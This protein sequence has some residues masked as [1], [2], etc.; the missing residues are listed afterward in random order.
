MA[1]GAATRNLFMTKPE[2]QHDQPIILQERNQWRR[3]RRIGKVK[4]LLWHSRGVVKWRNGNETMEGKGKL[5]K[6]EK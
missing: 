1:T 6:I 4:A 3:R 5:K 2:L